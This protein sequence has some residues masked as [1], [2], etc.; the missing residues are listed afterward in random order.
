M[1]LQKINNHGKQNKNYNIINK[2]LPVQA[3]CSLFTEVINTV[4]AG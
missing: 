4:T 2:Y 3:V 1:Y